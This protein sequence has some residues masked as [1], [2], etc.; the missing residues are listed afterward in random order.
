VRRAKRPDHPTV[1]VPSQPSPIRISL[2]I[3]FKEMTYVLISPSL[4]S[5]DWCGR[6]VVPRLM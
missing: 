2:R 3:H 6:V 5:G 1:T 4:E